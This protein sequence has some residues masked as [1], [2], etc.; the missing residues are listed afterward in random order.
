MGSARPLALF[1]PRMDDG[2]A[3]RVMLQLG[4]S[5]AARGLTVDLVVA[6]AGGPL[7]NQIP[8]AV[9]RVDL[10]AKRTVMALPALV[11]YLRRA[12]PLAIL[13]TLEHSNVL[14]VWATSIARTGVRV[15][16]REANVL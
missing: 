12:R 7:D 4:A 2:G 14:S 6:T 5:F 13:S 10:A 11:G 16:L 8:S 15:V 3:E 9:R 1:L